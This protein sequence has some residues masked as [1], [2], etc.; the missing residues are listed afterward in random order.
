MNLQKRIASLMLICSL[1]IGLL[2]IPAGASGSSEESTAR[3]EK[4]ASLG[5]LQGTG[6][7]YQLD[8]VPTRIQ[9]VVMLL[10]LLG[11]EDEALACTEPSPFSDVTWGDNYVSYAYQNGLT[12]GT[13]AQAFSPNATLDAKSYVTFLLRAL[14]YSDADG[15]FTWAGSLNFAAQ[16]SMMNSAAASTLAGVTM[17]RGDM[18]DLSYAALTCQMK[19]GG[20]TLAEHL[21]EQG[22]FTA[23]AATAAGVL[24]GSGWIYTYVPYDNSTID[25]QV[26]T[27]A[28][29]TAHVF[30]VN[31]HNPKVKVHA[32]MVN[33]TVGATAPFSTI[34]N[35]S[36]GAKLVMNANF[37]NAS[38][39]L[40]S[41]N[42][43]VI[44]NGQLMFINSGYNCLGITA[45]GSLMTGRPGLFIR[46]KASG[47]N[48]WSAYEMNTAAQS[49]SYSNLYSRAFGSSVTFTCA[50]NALVI[51]NN[52]ITAFYPVSAGTAVPIPA[53]GYVMFMG[54]GFMGTS[55]F[56]TP[57]V[58]ESVTITPYL[59][60]ED[61]EGF[62]IEEVV[63]LVS[64]GPRLVQD[65]AIYTQ[66]E[67][68]FTEAR[69][70]T[71]VSP[72]SAAGINAQGKLVLVSVPGGATIQQMRE[73]MLGLGCVDAINLDGGAS[74]AMY[75]NGQ[76]IATPG[77]ELT[78]TLQVSVSP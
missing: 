61:A 68:P 53:N 69:F 44:A 22:V 76:Y 59:L 27:L 66:L 3:A 36:G 72:R 52:T 58:G 37:F 65:G 18:A 13:S 55:Y 23:A 60:K 25:Y 47:G 73:L 46:V 64:G 15:D 17:N 33:G 7:G 67:A 8:E 39:N 14:G 21:V 38:S 9:G 35:N 34:V 32:S 2:I 56:R 19:E 51:E 70:T 31:T 57:T 28:G 1:L 5:L 26:K 75:Y 54:S 74:C 45:D 4:L 11:L 10:R 50:G 29:V 24:G 43:H 49:D 16:L 48:E 41:P 78:T 71:I 40:K 30:T 42:G 62:Q 77:R 63:D 20:Q 6:G 12:Q